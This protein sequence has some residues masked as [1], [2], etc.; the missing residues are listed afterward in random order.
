MRDSRPLF[1][2]PHHALVGKRA[3]IS[4]GLSPAENGFKSE[5]M[6][7]CVAL[8]SETRRHKAKNMN[9][10]SRKVPE[11]DIRCYFFHLS[12]ATLLCGDRVT[13]PEPVSVRTKL[14]PYRKTLDSAFN[15]EAKTKK[16]R[17]AS[18]P[19]KDLEQRLSVK[20]GPAAGFLFDGERIAIDLSESV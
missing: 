14:K 16:R 7:A 5:G 6:S 17:S 12:S 1:T 15:H 4:G 8:N 9:E 3:A 10:T 13:D 18:S 19:I 11:C 20:L 2:T